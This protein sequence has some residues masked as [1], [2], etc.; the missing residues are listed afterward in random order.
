MEFK[1]LYGFYS[2]LK[3]NAYNRQYFILLMLENQRQ[4][5]KLRRAWR[6]F[7]TRRTRNIV[8]IWRFEKSMH[9]NLIQQNRIRSAGG[10]SPHKPPQGI[11][12]TFFK[13]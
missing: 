5:K 2:R 13:S 10:L 6:C 11:G 1:V 3:N 7:I 4:R 8:T 9:L 12:A